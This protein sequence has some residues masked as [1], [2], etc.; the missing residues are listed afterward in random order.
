MRENPLNLTSF[1]ALS[2]LAHGALLL[3]LTLPSQDSIHAPIGSPRLSISLSTVAKE[4]KRSPISTSTKP[5]QSP[6]VFNQKV[7]NQKASNLGM[8]AQESTQQK[9]E[10]DSAK[11]AAT[12]SGSDLVETASVINKQHV[13]EQKVTITTP[14]DTVTDMTAVEQIAQRNFT[15]GEIQNRLSRY[16]LYPKRARRRGWEGDV[17]VGFNVSSQGFLSNI[18]LRQTSGYSLLDSAALTAIEKVINIPLSQWNGNFHPITMVL[19]V[20]YRLT[21]S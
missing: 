19:P 11:I 7:S 4:V 5:A 16:L 20:S 13:I 15:L 21:N 6:L 3:A 2:L 12:L 1:I 18:H 17:M 10:S 8:R 9:I 14:T